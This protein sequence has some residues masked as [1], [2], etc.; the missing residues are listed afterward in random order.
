M[1]TTLTNKNF[2]LKRTSLL[3]G[4][5]LILLSFIVAGCPAGKTVTEEKVVIRGSNTIGEELAPRLIAE[6]KKEHSAV[7][8]DLES[9]GTG[10]GLGNL[11]SDGCNI[12]AASRMANTNEVEWAR[13]RGIELKEYIIGTYSVAV[14]VSAGNLVGNLTQDQVRDIFTGAVKNWKEVGGPDAA[15]HL[16]IRDPISGTYLGFQELAMGNKPYAIGSKTFTNYTA[17][18]QAVAKDEH[19]IGYSSIELASSPDVKGVSIGGAAPTIPS[20]NKG[21]YPYS[22]VLRFYTNKASEAA[23][24]RD[25]IQFVQSP[26]GQQILTQ[27]GFVPRP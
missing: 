3:R 20:V 21:Q 2:G 14:I 6:Y 9:K 22:R 8:F 23:T 5:G 24:A 18:A 13:D 19:S 7:V 25:F 1:K 26:R 15:I 12:A 27:M 11:L 16:F 4:I 17:I 10:Y